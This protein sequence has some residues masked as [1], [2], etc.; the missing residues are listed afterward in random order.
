MGRSNIYSGGT[1]DKLNVYAQLAEPSK[2]DGIWIKTTGI[3]KYNYTGIQTL[4]EIITEEYIQLTNIPYQFYYGS[5]VAIGND[6]YL[7][8]GFGSATKAYKYQPGTPLSNGYIYI[9]TPDDAYKVKLSKLL[10]MYF[11][12]AY[13][14]DNN[15]LL[16][17]PCY[18]GDGTNWNLI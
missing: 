8:G 12:N 6:V 17:Y 10:Q 1:G 15:A 16:D 3:N 5:A 18:Y 7:F 13:I 9:L 4:N 11:Y 14:Y 2:K